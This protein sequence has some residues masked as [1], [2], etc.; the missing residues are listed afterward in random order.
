MKQ[1][2]LPWLILLVLVVIISALLDLA[3]LPSPVL[4]GALVA[5]LGYALIAPR[6]PAVPGFAFTTG[7]AILGAAIGSTLEPSTITA[8]GADWFPVLLSCLATL[9]LSVAAGFVLTIKPGISTA[10]GVFA[11][12]AGGASGIVAISR[13]LG[14]DDRVVAVVQYLRVLI[15]L[16]GMPLVA[17]VVF[18]PE[19][20]P[21]ISFLVAESVEPAHGGLAIA[22]LALVIGLPLARFV[23]MP[24]GALLFPLIVAAVLAG[25]GTITATVPNWLENVGFALIGLQVGL[26]FT[27]ESLKAVASVLPLAVA[28]I[29]GLIVVS[30]GLGVALA[31]ATG[32]TPLEGYLATTPG[33]LYAV[34]AT[35][36]GSGADVTFVLM[37][38]VARLFVMLFC[39]P[40]LAR[41]LAGPRT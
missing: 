18:S 8:L 19:P 25:T 38:Q 10:T 36:V 21:G 12:I 40:L 2:A 27:R 37:V 14:A 24:A 1:K 15:I 16:L 41:L 32:R 13:D 4:F 6:T 9:L 31:H 17:Q 20:A 28:A 26:R 30:A 39:A 23:P 34:L 35:A 29:I 22:A 3:G 11:M 33:G 7:Q 5:G